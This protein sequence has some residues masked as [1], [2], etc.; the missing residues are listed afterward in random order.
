MDRETTSDHLILVIILILILII[1]VI[2]VYLSSSYRKDSSYDG[3]RNDQAPSRPRHYPYPHQR[4]YLYP[5]PPPSYHPA[6]KTAA[7]KDR[8][9]AGKYYLSYGRWINLTMG[10][11]YLFGGWRNLTV[12][13]DYY[14]GCWGNISVGD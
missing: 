7:L 9:T 11:I 5:C 4:P 8:E 1:V 10:K 14:S 12:G 3:Q 6:Q 13:H 2:L